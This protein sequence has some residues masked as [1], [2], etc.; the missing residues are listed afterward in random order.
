MAQMQSMTGIAEQIGAEAGTV[1]GHHA[2]RADSEASEPVDR[3]AQ[4]HKLSRC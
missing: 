3:L 4:K 2:T 1:V